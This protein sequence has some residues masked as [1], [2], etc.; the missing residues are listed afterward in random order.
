MT[1]DEKIL[2]ISCQLNPRT[3]QNDHLPRAN[4]LHPRVAEMVQ[5]T[6]IHQCNTLHNQ[7]RRKKKTHIMSFDAEKPL[8]KIHHPFMLKAL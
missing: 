5:Y 8:D 1:T 7:T 3:R 2:K 4:R 6:E